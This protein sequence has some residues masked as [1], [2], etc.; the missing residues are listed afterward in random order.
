MDTLPEWPPEPT[1]GTSNPGSDTLPDIPAIVDLANSDVAGA[2]PPVRRR[3][4]MGRAARA[5]A[6]FAKAAPEMVL[7]FIEGLLP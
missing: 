3:H 7:Q 2:T 1:P 6:D 4:A 5:S